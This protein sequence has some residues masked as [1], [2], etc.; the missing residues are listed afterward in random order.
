MYGNVDLAAYGVVYSLSEIY[1]M[2]VVSCFLVSMI[3]QTKI[4]TNY[5]TNLSPAGEILHS[6]CPLGMQLPISL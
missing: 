1:N 5:N 6:L 3:L 2:D 4:V